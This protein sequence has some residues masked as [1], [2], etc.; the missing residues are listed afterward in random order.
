M[1]GDDD[2]ITTGTANDNLIGGTGND[3]LQGGGGNDTYVFNLG[4]GI[5][6]ITDVESYQPY[7][8]ST[9]TQLR[10]GGDDTIRFGDDI[11]ADDLIIK[12][13]ADSSDLIVAL[14]EDGV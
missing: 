12:A 10:N 6:T 8:S 1:L 14:K 9:Y 13:S 7:Y 2:Y 5:D 4:D 11:T 3:T